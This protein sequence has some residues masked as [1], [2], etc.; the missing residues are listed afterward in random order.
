MDSFWAYYDQEVIYQMRFDIAT[1]KFAVLKRR[2]LDSN[3]NIL[4]PFVHNS[5]VLSSNQHMSVKND[6]ILFL[7]KHTCQDMSGFS[8]HENTLEVKSFVIF[9]LKGHNSPK[10]FDTH[11]M[12]SNMIKTNS[13]LRNC[14]DE[15]KF[16][17]QSKCQQSEFIY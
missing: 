13:E 10:C 7:S 6:Q 17:N 15:N 16:G 2:P 12:F 5:N 14:L 1:D 8:G 9:D 3:L 11:D 4:L